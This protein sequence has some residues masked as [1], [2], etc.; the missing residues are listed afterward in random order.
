MT[1]S[2]DP[3]IVALERDVMTWA[4][5]WEIVASIDDPKVFY[6]HVHA[7]IWSAVLEAIRRSLS[8]GYLTVRQILTER[9]H[10]DVVGA[11]YLHE[12]SR[13]SVRPSDTV[14]QSAADQ[15]HAAAEQRRLRA[16]LRQHVDRAALD[17]DALIVDLESQ[18]TPAGRAR[19]LLDDVAVLNLPEQNDIIEGM[20]KDVSLNCL[21]GESGIGKTFVAIDEGLSIAS[22][23]PFL[24]ARILRPG[25]VILVAAEGAPAKRIAGWKLAHGYNLDKALGFHVWP[26]AVQLMEPASVTAFIAAAKA[27]QPVLVILDTYARCMVGGDE[28]SA[29]DAGIAV[30]GM[31]RIRLQLGAA[32][33]VNHHTN[34]TGTSERG[35]GALRAACDSMWHLSNADDLLQLSCSKQK[36]AEPFA[37]INLKLVPAYEGSATRIVKRAADVIVDDVLTDAQGKA[38]HALREVFGASGADGKEW[39][40]A[41]SMIS[42]ATFFRARTVLIERGYVIEANRRFT[43]SGKIPVSRSLTASL[44]ETSRQSQAVA[45]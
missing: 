21:A 27:V 39:E 35:S 31:D 24:G 12:L 19:A 40:S 18:R 45:S 44:T 9:G 3:L 32:V 2:T 16:V 13:D 17:Y 42:R 6:R 37:P 8:P 30:A 10:L 15:I 41:V 20:L 28:N 38:L 26:G 1:D 33:K 11:V 43:W 29:K 14:L 36:D 23:R 7:P 25:P 4:L 34:K 22:S 5:E